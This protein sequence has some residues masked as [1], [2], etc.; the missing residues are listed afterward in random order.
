MRKAV[1]RGRDLIQV[2]VHTPSS[3]VVSEVQHNLCSYDLMVSAQQIF[4]YPSHL[5]L[6]TQPV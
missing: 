2:M 3:P 5:R 4:H 6:L 1:T